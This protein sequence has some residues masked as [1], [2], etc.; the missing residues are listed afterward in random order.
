M[1]HKKDKRIILQQI[2]MRAAYKTLRRK[3]KTYYGINDDLINIKQS[4]T[5]PRDFRLIHN[6]EECLSFFIK[7]RSDDIVSVFQNKKYIRIVLKSVQ[8]ID[9]AAISILTAIS[10]DLKSNNIFIIGDFPENK[11]CKKFFLNQAF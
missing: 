2:R 3:K 5:A 8:Q 6:I 1:R 10:D 7:L 9:Y 11:E 4:V